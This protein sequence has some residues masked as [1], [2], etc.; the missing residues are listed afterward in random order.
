MASILHYKGS[1]TVTWSDGSTTVRTLADRV[2]VSKEYLP[3]GCGSCGDLDASVYVTT[4][5]DGWTN[6]S[7]CGWCYR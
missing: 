1:E 2:M 7:K 4:Y 3:V 6:H 5:A